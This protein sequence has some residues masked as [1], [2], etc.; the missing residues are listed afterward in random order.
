MDEILHKLASIGLGNL[1]PAQLASVLGPE[2]MAVLEQ[3]D[4]L[5]SLRAQA[6]PSALSQGTLER[7]EESFVRGRKQD[8]AH[9]KELLEASAWH[10]PT[11]RANQICT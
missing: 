10:V 6:P 1:S 7:D 9:A 8:I 2:K 5:R 4:G 3:M 11:T